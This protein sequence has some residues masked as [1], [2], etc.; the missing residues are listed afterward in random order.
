M[1]KKVLKF[2]ADSKQLVA[3]ERVA[4]RKRYRI[5]HIFH[6]VMDEEYFEYAKRKRV[7]QKISGKDDVQITS[8]DQNLR[9]SAWLWDKLIIE[10]QGYV[11]SENWRERVSIQE[12]DAAIRGL[13]GVAID[14]T[15]ESIVD[16][17]EG[18]LLDDSQEEQ[19]IVVPLDALYHS[20]I[21]D[22][23]HHFAPPSARDVEDFNRINSRSM[24]IGG[25]VGG[26]LKSM[27]STE[28]RVVSQA[29]AL[30]KLYDRLIEKTEGYRGR[31]P[32]YH[33]EAAVAEVFAN[34]VEAREKN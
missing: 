28:V 8:E 25:R 14:E 31:V 1:T 23:F 24:S 30:A 33:K 11:A 13:L 15:D 5:A 2:N 12:K 9:A 22:T 34:E 10:R 6:P 3:M 32:A 19:E 17:E 16:A 26:I 18:E 20:Q 21:V 7:V 29:K 27:T 4:N